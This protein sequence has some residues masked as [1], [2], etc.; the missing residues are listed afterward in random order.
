[1]ILLC[2][3][4]IISALEIGFLYIIIFLNI[5][6]IKNHKMDNLPYCIDFINGHCK[7]YPH[8]KLGHIIVEDK[9]TFIDNY[10]RLENY[11][12]SLQNFCK[13]KEILVSEIKREKQIIGLLIK[14]LSCGKGLQIYKEK[15]DLNDKNYHCDKCK[16]MIN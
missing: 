9:I 11:F 7:N 15:L 8:C 14:C 10:Q 3:I 2:Q 13:M 6:K 5:K 12:I 16:N 4:F 1:M